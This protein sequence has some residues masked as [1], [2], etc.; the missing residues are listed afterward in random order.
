MI[1]DRKKEARDKKKE[2]N[3]KI[4]AALNTPINPFPDKE[5]CAYEK[6]RES[7]IREREEAME[8][9]GFF[10]DLLDYKKN[11]GLQK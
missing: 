1:E 9:S 5:L 7:N 10:A 8:K 11:I 4:K 6:L 2:R 3:E